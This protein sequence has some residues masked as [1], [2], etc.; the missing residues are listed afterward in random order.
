MA[1]T[2]KLTFLPDGSVKKETAGFSG[3]ECISKT[4]FVEDALG[5]PGERR[6]KDEYYDDGEK[7]SN[8]K[9]SW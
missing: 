6:F 3:K 7:Q 4:K 5:T 2:I 8:N 9:V 1:K